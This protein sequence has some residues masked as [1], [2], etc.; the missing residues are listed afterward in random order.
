MVHLD[1][2]ANLGDCS[3]TR[4]ELRSVVE[5]LQLA[6]SRG[7]RHIIIQVDSLCAVQLLSN[8]ADCDHQLASIIA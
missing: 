7:F 3:I 5:C 2:A 6:W 1:F 4:A 8:L